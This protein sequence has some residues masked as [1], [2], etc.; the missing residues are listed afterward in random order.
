[1]KK[2]SSLKR[3]IPIIIFFITAIISYFIIISGKTK[4]GIDY[5]M[6]DISGSALQ[7]LVSMSWTKGKDFSIKNLSDSL[8]QHILS[9]NCTSERCLETFGFNKCIHA[10]EK[11][12]CKYKAKIFLADSDYSHRKEKENEIIINI[13]SSLSGNEITSSIHHYKDARLFN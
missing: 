2:Q 4:V 3:K 11:I 10:E 6:D 1:M 13:E 12:K 9:N 8:S 7:T 5:R